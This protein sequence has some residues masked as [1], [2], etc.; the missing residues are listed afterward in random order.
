MER[1]LTEVPAMPVTIEKLND[2]EI[3]GRGIRNWPV[4]EKEVSTFP[5]FYDSPEMCLFL[6][7]EVVVTDKDTGKR[8]EI[9][10]GD[11]VTFPAD[12]ACTWEVRKPV[13]KHYRFE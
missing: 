11:F 13:K 4:W 3:R 8:Y 9:R 6:E 1:Y 12:M 5:W 2:A 10:K 7:G